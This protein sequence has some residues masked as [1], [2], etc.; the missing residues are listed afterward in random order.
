MSDEAEQ[1]YQRQLAL[2]KRLDDIRT[3]QGR[4]FSGNNNNN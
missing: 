3:E 1:R 4:L 2:D